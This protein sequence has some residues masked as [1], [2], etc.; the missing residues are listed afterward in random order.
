MRIETT[1]PVNFMNGLRTALSA[2]A[3]VRR[4][5]KSSEMRLKIV[6]L[7]AGFGFILKRRRLSR[8]PLKIAE[9]QSFS[10]D[11]CLYQLKIRRLRGACKITFKGLAKKI[12]RN[13]RQFFLVYPPGVGGGEGGSYFPIGAG[14]GFPVPEFRLAGSGQ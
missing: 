14:A 1:H 3:Y 11:I 13:C 6:L 2:I 10:T 9:L 4:R 8:E 7:N 5:R 12:A